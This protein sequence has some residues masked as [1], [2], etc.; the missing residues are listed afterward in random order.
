MHP[1]VL[2]QALVGRVR[3]GWEDTASSLSA[4]LP[5]RQFAIQHHPLLTRAC[6]P[7]RRPA[8]YQPQRPR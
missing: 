5:C 2:G 7:H 6:C 8:S 4:I 3:L 1:Q